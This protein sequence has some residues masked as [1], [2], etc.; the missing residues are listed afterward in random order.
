MNIPGYNTEHTPT[1]WDKGGALLNISKELI[2]KSRNN[3]KFYKHKNLESV[4]LEV[5]S[6]SDKNTITKVAMT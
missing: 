2:Y 6:K 5:L 4:F 1:K 3:L